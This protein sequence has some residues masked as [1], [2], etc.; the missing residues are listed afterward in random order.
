M[1]K[2]IFFSS[3]LLFLTACSTKESTLKHTLNS[4]CDFYSLKT[5]LCL[6]ESQMVQALEPYQVIFIGDHHGEDNMHLKVA[7][8]I[9]ALSKRGTKVHLANEWFYPNDQE[10]LDKFVSSNLN[11]T[12]F[13]KAIKWKERLKYNKYSS[14]KPMYEAVKQ[15]HGQLHGINLSKKERKKISKQS[16]SVM[17]KDERTFNKT[18]DLQVAPHRALIIPFLSH[19][20]AP[21]KGESLEQCQERMYRVQVAWDTKM[22]IESYK[23][24]QK[25]KPNEKLIVFAGAMHIETRL[26]IPLRFA[27]LTNIPFVTIIPAD[28]TTK[29]VDNDAGD[30]ILFYN[31]MPEE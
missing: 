17:N 8:L 28:T 18:L 10:V 20:H 19:C 4:G 15:N 21:K 13:L 5:A 14:F 7:N 11:E 16:I 12:E 27:R 2:L 23:L 31:A 24:S 1:F 6:N 3:L 25:L 29:E 30:Y 22:A 26:G 9:T